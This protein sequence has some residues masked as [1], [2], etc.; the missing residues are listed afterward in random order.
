M[1]KRFSLLAA[2]V[3]VMFA[4]NACE[5]DSVGPTED[6]T[7]SAPINL[8]ATSADEATVHL[9]WNAPGDL[10]TDLFQNYTVTYYP[11]G[12][13]SVDA[14]TM[15][16][17]DAGAPFPVTGLDED[18]V[19][20]FE[21][22]TNYTNGES[23]TVVSINWAPAMR[24]DMID[25]ETIKVYSHTSSFGSG[26]KLYDDTFEE[27]ELMT[28]SDIAMWN[29][30]LDTKTSGEV[31][32]GSASMTAYNGAATATMSAEISSVL[33]PADGLNDRFESETL[34]TK[35]FSARVEDLSAASSGQKAGVVMYARVPNGDT[36]NYAKLFVKSV[37]GSF[38]QG[39]GDDQYVEVTISYQ[40]NAGFPYAKK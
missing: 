13:G 30:A 27:P 14:P 28:V 6:E 40:A 25:A 3:A 31:N 23:S 26:L 7:P 10:D 1:I 33:Y 9:M 2:L 36:Y 21:V 11:E 15:D 37:D 39:T 38:L 16:A 24:F 4:F 12:T 18:K 17:D 5:E 20:T 19:Y 32:F 8:M 34:D 22:V 29:L 35:S